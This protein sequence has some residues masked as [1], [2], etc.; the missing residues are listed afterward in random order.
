MK[1]KNESFPNG[2][3]AFLLV[4]ALFIIE[5]LIGAGIHDAN[6]ILN[7][8]PSEQGALVAVLANGTVFAAVMLF[9]NLTYSNLFHPSSSSPAVTFLLLLMP[10][11][12]VVPALTLGISALVG[13]L[14]ELLPVSLAEQTMFER[15]MSG[16]FPSIV[17][18]CLLAP[19]L[20]EMLFRGI[21]LRSFLYQ[22]S[23]W[24]AILG[25]AVLFGFAHLN[26]YQF[27]A[28]TILGTLL[29]WLYE[30]TRSLIPCIFLHSVYNTALMI[31]PPGLQDQATEFGLAATPTTWLFVIVLATLGMFVL[32]YMLVHRKKHRD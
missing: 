30:R 22:S 14:A 10:I 11:L 26:I 18:A 3:Q 15:M 2:A 19:V 29:G 9:K 23:R 7:L 17:A 5:A 16:S 1:L 21:V 28:A 8:E 27:T 20:E 25:S 24:Q 6:G 32:N 13:L 4:V 12:M 31:G